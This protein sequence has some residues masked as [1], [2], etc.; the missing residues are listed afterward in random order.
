MLALGD[1]ALTDTDISF[2]QQAAQL[3]DLSVPC[4]LPTRKII[5]Q[6]QKQMEWYIAAAKSGN[7]AAMSVLG[8]AY[9]L[10]Y[11]EKRDDE[12][13]FLWSSRAADLGD[14]D[15]MYQ[16]AYFYENG[17]GTEKDIG[18]ALLLYTEAAEQGVRSAAVWLYEIYT[19]GLSGIQPDGKMAAHYLFL[20]RAAD[21]E[22][23]QGEAE[24]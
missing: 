9:H 11:P 5:K 13:A 1:L 19:N 14:A 17:F 6:H 2:W 3:R 10:G 18:A 8:M 7:T 22:G 12:Q 23:E 21:T 4:K 15:A 20:S 24:N 16:T